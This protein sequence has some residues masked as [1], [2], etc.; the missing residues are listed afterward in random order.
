MAIFDERDS[1]GNQSRWKQVAYLLA[2]HSWREAFWVALGRKSAW[3][4]GYRPKSH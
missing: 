1:I 4:T 3:Q 2:I